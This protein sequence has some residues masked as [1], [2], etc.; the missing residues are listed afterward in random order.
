[1]KVA[2]ERLWLLIVIYSVCLSVSTAQGS[3]WQSVLGIHFYN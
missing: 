1:M 2:V 3:V